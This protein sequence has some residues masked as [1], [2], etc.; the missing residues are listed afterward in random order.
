MKRDGRRVVGEMPW[1]GDG[2]WMEG[3]R[4]RVRFEDTV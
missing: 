2:Q 4:W 1:M 3:N